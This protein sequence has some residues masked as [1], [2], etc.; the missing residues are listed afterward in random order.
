MKKLR[1]TSVAL[2]LAL[3]ESAFAQAWPSKPIRVIVPFSPGG[4]VDVVARVVMEQVSKEVGQPIIVDNRVGAG[5]TIGAAAV[6]KAEPDGYTILVHSSSHTVSPAL[7]ANLPYDAVRD[8]A[9]VIP[10]GSQPTA[11]FVPADRGYATVRDFVTSAKAGKMS[12][13]SGGVG[14]ATHLN[15]ERFQLSAGF[16]AEHVPFKGSP[17]ALREVAAGRIDFSFSTLTPALPLVKEGRIKVLAV[18]SRQRASALPDV[19]TTLEAGYPDSDYNFWIGV[20]VPRGTNPAIID[21]LYRESAKALQL[22]VVQE[23]LRALG[24]DPMPMSSA[25]FDKLIADEV[26]M[27]RALVKAA[28]IPT[29]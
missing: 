1:V 10:L 9:A 20:L 12:Y 21:R 27:N 23:R 22:P 4:A 13:G 3:C 11:L 29:N 19:P 7:M 2:L 28:G 24:A 25:E 16:K 26:A 18:S 14:N 5:G 6:A 17:E 8:F 15:A